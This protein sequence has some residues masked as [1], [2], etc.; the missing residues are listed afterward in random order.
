MAAVRHL[1][2]SYFRNI[3]Q[4]F[5]ICA[6]FCVDMRNS[7]KFGRSA[8]ELLHIVDFSSIKRFCYFQGPLKGKVSGFIMHLY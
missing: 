5:K 1:G 4:K 2:F 6:Y 3:C 7:V 8:A